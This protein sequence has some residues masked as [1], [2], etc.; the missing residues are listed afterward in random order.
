MENEEGNKMETRKLLGKENEEGNEMKTR[1][2][3]LP[4]M[5]IFVF[6]T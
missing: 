3:M 4:R 6:S 1:K 5:E 2:L